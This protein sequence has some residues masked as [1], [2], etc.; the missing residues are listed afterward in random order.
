[1]VINVAMRPFEVVHYGR[2]SRVIPGCR[3]PQYSLGFFQN[4]GPPSAS[5]LSLRPQPSPDNEQGSEGSKGE[6]EAGRSNRPSAR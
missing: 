1:M 4:R 5:A 3:A 6:E 2:F